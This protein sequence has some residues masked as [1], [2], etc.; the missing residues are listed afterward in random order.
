LGGAL[1]G[2]VGKQPG[3]TEDSDDLDGIVADAVDNA[4]WT[5]DQLAEFGLGAFGNDAT[6]FWEL[7][8][9]I[10]G[11]DKALHYEISVQGRVLRNM[12]ANGLEIPDGPR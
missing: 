2:Y 9:A 1:P 10:G 6:Q 7:L 11:A 4:E 3:G 5:N 12:L 8:Q